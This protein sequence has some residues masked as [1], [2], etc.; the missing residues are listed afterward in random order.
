M[1]LQHIFVIGLNE[2]NRAKLE[3]LPEA[4]SYRFHELLTY[5]EVTEQ[6]EYPVL[7]LL[8]KA[9]RRLVDFQA[10]GGTV[11]GVI[12]YMDFPVSTMVPVLSERFGLRSASVSSFIQ[13]EHK[14]WSRLRQ[15]EVI[16]E[17]IPRFCLFDPF[18]PDAA[19]SIELDY[20][21]WIKPVKSFGSHLGF[22]IGSRKDLDEAL[23]IVRR[24]ITRISRPFDALLEHLDLDMPEQVRSVSGH[25]CLAEE[26][27]GGWQCTL[28]GCMVDGELH[29]HGIVDSIRYP[30]RSVFLRYQYPSALPRR[31]QLQMAH[32]GKRFLNY[33]GFDQS[34]FNM[35]FFWDRKRDKISMLEVNTRVAQHH[36]DLFQKVDGVSNHQVPV[37]LALGRKA[38]IPD[39][40]GPYKC[41][42]VFFHRKFEDAWV[43]AV[44]EP[45]EIARIERQLPGT[46]IQVDIEPGMMLSDLSEQDSYSYICA[47]IYM[48]AKD[49]KSLLETYQRCLG[50]LDF[51]L[52]PV[53]ASRT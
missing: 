27:I 4:G 46:R 33:I 15:R 25:H 13:C 17:H 43:D 37:D 1:S 26:L 29:A 21:F 50:N 28:E 7:S 31:I 14:Y 32:I 3:A 35:E 44:P 30:G 11:H 53:P 9:E 39:R 23:P 34:A 45:G 18:D 12:G 41:A 2:F 6:D 52:Y 19:R 36:S 16:P 40:K 48:G 47:L 10:G 38:V 24:N 49:Q 22:R 51:K 5:D 42:A 8:D 20:P